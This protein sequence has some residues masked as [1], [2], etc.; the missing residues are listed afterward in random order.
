MNILVQSYM[1]DWNTW[2]NLVLRVLDN[3]SDILIKSY[4][5]ICIFWFILI[6]MYEYFGSILYEC[7]NILVQFYVV[8]WIVLY[9][10]MNILVLN[11]I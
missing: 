7:V 4:M 11:S 8:M 1:E 2:S 10:C 9:G 6:W 5:D 3:L